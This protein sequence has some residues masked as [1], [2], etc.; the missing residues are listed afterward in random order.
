MFSKCGELSRVIPMSMRGEGKDKS[1]VARCQL[2]NKLGKRWDR[3]INHDRLAACRVA[4]QRNVSTQR[5]D[6][7]D[8]QLNRHGASPVALPL[9]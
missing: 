4:D 1:P 8:E 7:E 5:T 6:R 9:G 3:R 2:G